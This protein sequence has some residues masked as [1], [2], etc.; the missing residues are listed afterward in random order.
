MPDRFA[1][2]MFP[3]G[4][5]PPWLLGEG[6]ASDVVMSSRVRLAR[7]LSNLPFLP[8]SDRGHRLAGLELCKA[9]ITRGALG[10]HLRWMP[11]H[12]STA[13]QRMLLVERHLI[14]KQHSKGR[15]IPGGQSGDDPRAVAYSATD[16]RLSIMVNEEDHLR[17]QVVT[18]G[19][20]LRSAWSM[21]D[22]VD[23]RLEDGLEYAFSGRFGYLTACATNV[24]TGLRMS[25]MLHLPALR[26]TGELE[27]VKRAAQA[28][29]LA[30]R[31]FYGEGSEA[32]GDFFQISNQTTLGRTE[33]SVLTDL[34]SD[35]LP[36][37]V[38][39]ERLS[40]RELLTK[41]RTGLEDQIFRAYGILINA[42]LLST[43]EAMQLL[44]MLRLGVVLGVVRDVS[45]S[46]VNR[47]MLHIQP[48][49]LQ[50]EL[51]LELDQERRRVER[52][53]LIRTRLSAGD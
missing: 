4:A 8:K 29:S 37:V 6:E 27:K 42:R 45:Q 40:R 2:D 23:D 52:A 48:A 33:E 38:E 50:R 19:L 53:T 44:S 20:S 41:R 39:Y 21:I 1:D 24:G 31:G 17:V 13:F 32:V 10:S 47:L 46:T 28:M 26:L 7:N 34:E 22:E 30:V 18:S 36:K 11:L 15:S 12:E 3:S 49:H 51:G 9:Q 35:I 14:S 16:E 43:D 25:A 5:I